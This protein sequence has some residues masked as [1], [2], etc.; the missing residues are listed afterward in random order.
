[1][2]MFKD[3]VAIVT[4]GAS[5]MGEAVCRK[6][7]AAGANVIVADIAVQKA[8]QV[9]EEIRAS[10]GK[11]QSVALDVSDRETVF[12]LVEDTARAFGRLDYMFNNAG[13]FILGEVR[14]TA[15]SQWDKIV[16]VNVTGVINGTLAAYSVM[17]RQGSGH[18][19]NTASA[20]GFSYPPITVAYCMTKQAVAGLSLSLRAEAASLGVKISTVCPGVV[21][22]PLYDHSPSVRAN[23]PDVMGVI[24]LR[25]CT[26]EKAAEKILAGVL[27]NK[28]M[29]LFPMH[30]RLVWLLYR[31][32][33]L[34]LVKFM[35]L[36][37]WYFRKKV[38]Q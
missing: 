22:T 24:P 6:L 20:A 28:A 27:K 9:A 29:I 33:P 30:S 15:P 1:M 14:D 23:I 25:G 37:V 34:V 26:A 36:P 3:K 18:I 4:G 19:I 8:E 10:G 17:I 31:L 2:N 35:E 11:A 7:A 38:R 32:M 5:G 13:I 12:S 21:K 16:R